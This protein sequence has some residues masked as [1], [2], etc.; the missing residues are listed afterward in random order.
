M[1]REFE[2]FSGRTLIICSRNIF[3]SD[4]D[5]LWFFGGGFL[6]VILSS[7]ILGSRLDI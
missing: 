3:L 2:G 7:L 1:G 4:S 6:L 5:K